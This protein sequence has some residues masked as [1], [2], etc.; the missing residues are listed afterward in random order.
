MPF[1]EPPLEIDDVG[2]VG[3]ADR[4]HLCDPTTVVGTD[5]GETG[6]LVD[7]PTGR[8]DQLVATPRIGLPVDAAT[9]LDGR[10]ESEER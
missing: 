1:A 10:A 6:P 3:Q 4:R 7:P 9:E 8:Q 5:R 2:A